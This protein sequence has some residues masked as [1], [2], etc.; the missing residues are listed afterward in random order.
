VNPDPRGEYP[1]GLHTLS[2]F[3][4]RTLIDGKRS[5]FVPTEFF[6]V[7]GHYLR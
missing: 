5:V 6:R 2:R 1:R 3:G 4:D 7:L